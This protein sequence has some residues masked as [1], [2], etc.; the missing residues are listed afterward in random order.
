MVGQ[1]ARAVIAG[2]H[3]VGILL[4]RQ[5][6]RAKT[7]ADLDALD[8]VDAHHRRRQFAVELGVDRRAEAGRH[9][10]LFVERRAV[11][12]ECVR[13]GGGAPVSFAREIADKYCRDYWRHDLANLVLPDRT[14]S[15]QDGWILQTRAGEIAHSDYRRYCYTA[16]NL[17]DRI[18]LSET[19][20][21]RTLRMIF[22]RPKERPFTDEDTARIA[23]MAH[24]LLA[25]VRRHADHGTASRQNSLAY[26]RERLAAVA[27]SLT[28]RETEVCAAIILGLTSE[29]I[30]LELG[31]GLNTVL[32]YK[33]RAY[34]RLA[35]S[36]QNQLMRLVLS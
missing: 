2:A 29:G 10:L 23:D 9:A 27:P 4:A 20:G 16:I 34:A 12:V 26:Y 18:S 31:V 35:I 17:D 1:K 5:F 24:L 15:A 11:G 36:S 32:T 33:K 3:L 6:G 14:A 28:P 30:A 21:D 22:Y 25:L 13:S 7:G 19:R 8:R